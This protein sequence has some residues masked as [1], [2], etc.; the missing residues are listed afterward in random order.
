MTANKG[1]SRSY[2]A[3][4]TCCYCLLRS[5]PRSPLPLA[6]LVSSPHAP[7]Q[8]YPAP[9]TCNAGGSDAS[10]SQ[11]YNHIELQRR[12]IK[13]AAQPSS[14]AAGTCMRS[15]PLA[16]RPQVQITYRTSA[17]YHYAGMMQV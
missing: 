8:T 17:S 7:V 10:T 4:C 9:R 13:K 5:L 1:H 12:R 3:G 11:S 16:C 15:L 2:V 6:F 14:D